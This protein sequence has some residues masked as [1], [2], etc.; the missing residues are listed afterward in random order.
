MND[1][2]KAWFPGMTFAERVQMLVHMHFEPQRVA[3]ARQKLTKKLAGGVKPE[4]HDD[5]RARLAEYDARLQ[6]I[7]EVWMTA[8]DEE[9]AAAHAAINEY[10]SDGLYRKAGA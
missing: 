2:A 1:D 9:R 10:T 5:Y 7:H 4:R 6:E 3:L 8:P